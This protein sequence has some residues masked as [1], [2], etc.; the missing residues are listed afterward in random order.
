M[1]SPITVP[2]PGLPEPTPTPPAPTPTQIVP[3][4]PYPVGFWVCHSL[5]DLENAPTYEGRV[6]GWAA[7]PMVVGPRAFKKG[8]KIILAWRTKLGDQPTRVRVF[9]RVGVGYITEGGLG[10]VLLEREYNTGDVVGVATIDIPDDWVGKPVALALFADHGSNRWDYMKTTPIYIATGDAYDVSTSFSKASVPAGEVDSVTVDVKLSKSHYNYGY[11]IS[12]WAKIITNDGRTLVNWF[13]L[14]HIIGNYEVRG[15]KA[16]TVPNLVGKHDLT[17]IVGNSPHGFSGTPRD[18]DLTIAGYGTASIEIKEAPPQ[19]DPNVFKSTIRAF[20][21]ITRDASK[22]TVGPG[23]RVAF[24]TVVK[25][26][27]NGHYYLVVDAPGKRDT[28][29]L[30][31]HKA[32]DEFS[33]D[34]EI[35]TPEQEGDY[36]VGIQLAV[37]DPADG[38]VKTIP[39]ATAG[40]SFTVRGGTLDQ[41]KNSTLSIDVPALTLTGKSATVKATIGAASSGYYMVTIHQGDT[42][43]GT[44]GE[45]VWIDKGESATLVGSLAFSQPGTYDLTFRLEFGTDGQNFYDTGITRSATVQVVPSAGLVRDWS[46]STD[47]QKAKPGEDVTVTVTVDWQVVSGVQFKVR[48]DWFGVPLESQP[49]APSESPAVIRAT[50]TVPEK[51]ASKEAS[52]TLLVGV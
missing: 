48:F 15:T 46:V 43:I 2:E 1:E 10:D 26:G 30:G 20:W 42:P 16:F 45:P 28:L 39:D 7:E 5:S 19:L 52:A 36:T 6:N 22:I 25:A 47:K 13:W 49:V 21:E 35:V 12:Y 32:G 34:H 51:P 33:V 50:L 24:W 3:D 8:E 14:G 17:V 41:A 9:Y 40:L 29:D 27:G 31:V 38:K 18:T 11:G 37:L 23:K 4:T 44:V